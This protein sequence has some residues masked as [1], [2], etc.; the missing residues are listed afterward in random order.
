[1]W[2]VY[3]AKCEPLLEKGVSVLHGCAFALLCSCK[4]SALG[5]GV[6]ALAPRVPGG[7]LLPAVAK[8]EREAEE[9]SYCTR[10]ASS[11][12]PRVKHPALAASMESRDT[13]VLRRLNLFSCMPSSQLA[14]PDF[15]R[16]PLQT[17]EFEYHMNFHIT[18]MRYLLPAR[19][20]S[21]PVL[22]G[23]DGNP[24]LLA[25]RCSRKGRPLVRAASQAQGFRL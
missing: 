17:L 12:M 10:E 15:P 6:V 16:L 20:D 3:R 14:G 25:L 19:A 13:C 11:M 4:S 2:Q 8:V 21:G 22:P 18:C 9:S 7:M 24:L 1:M 23:L 5:S